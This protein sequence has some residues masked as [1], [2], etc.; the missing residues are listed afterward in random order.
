MAA[1]HHPGGCYTLVV[2]E[3][4]FLLSVKCFECE[5]NARI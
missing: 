2:A 5:K 4:S 1:V 3:E